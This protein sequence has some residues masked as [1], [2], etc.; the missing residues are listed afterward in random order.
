MFE[1]FT[2][3]ARKAIVLARREAERLNADRIRTEHILLGIIQG[4]GI[5]ANVMKNLN[6]DVQRVRGEIERLSMPPLETAPDL[7]RFSSRG[8]RVIELAGE[9]A[10]ILGHDTIGTEHLLLGLLKDK[11]SIAAQVLTNLGLKLEE[12][13]DMVLDV[14]GA[15]AAKRDDDLP[16]RGATG[17]LESSP[18]I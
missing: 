18:G 3:G 13:R 15:E 10:E 11:E 5:A 17:M 4:D 12:V 1:R 6:V 14:M 7:S 16:G 2:E 9:V 8:A